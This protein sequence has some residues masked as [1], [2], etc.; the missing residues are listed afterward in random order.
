MW[1]NRILP[2]SKLLNRNQNF[3]G[4]K[5][6][7]DQIDTA[8]T[9]EN[10]RLVILSSFQ[11]TG[12]S[13]IA[14]EIG[15]RF[16]ERSLNQFVY[17]M[18][19]DEDNLNE[20]FRQFA[21]DLEVITED[22][23]LQKPIG[24][25]ITK[26][27]LSFRS[28]L[29]DNS[30]EEFLF[31]FDNCNEI[32]KTKEYFGLMIQDS[33]L[34]NV[35]FLVTTIVGTSFEKLE[36]I[37]NY[38]RECSENIII[39]PFKKEES[40]CF[41]KSKLNN[42]I[43]EE[44]ELNALISSLD[45]Q[46]E[47]PVTLV[48]I[49]ALVKVKLKSTNDLRGLIEEFK[50][51]KRQT[52]ALDELF[53]NL[54]E[55]EEKSWEILKQISFLDA[56]LSP[57]S[58]YTDLFKVQEKE[59]YDAID[60][61]TKLSLITTEEDDE[62]MEYGFRIHQ[63]LQN[64]AKKFLEIKYENEYNEILAKQLDIIE[65]ILKNQIE[66][67]QWNKQKY[68]N[69]FKQII[70]N[71]LN[72]KN[73]NDKN[74]PELCKKF[75]QY[76][77]DANL[78]IENSL[79]YFS[80]AIEIGRN[81]FGTDEHPLIVFTLNSIGLVYNKLGRNDEALN[82]FSESLELNRKIFGTGDNSSIADTLNNIALACDKLCNY[83]EALKNYSLSLE[84]NRRIF[85]TD[86]NTS[87]ADTL[88][89]IAILNFKLGKHEEA[90]EN[91]FK[92]LEI[93]R[94]IFGTEEDL[95]I[96]DNLNNIAMVYHD[97]DNH[98]AAL[99]NY[100]KSLEIYKKIFG[101]EE[102]SSVA[103]TLNN[104]GLVYHHLGRHEDALENYSKSLE[105]KQK[106][107]GTGQNLSIAH[108]LNNIG[109][110]NDA[111]DQYDEAIK[112]YS[113]SL[114]INRIILGTDEHSSIAD[115]LNNIAV[116]YNKVERYEEALENLSKSLEIK[117]N[118]FGTYQHLSIARTFSNFADVYYAQSKY[119]K[120]LENY[121]KSLEIKR[122]TLGTDEHKTVANTINNIGSVY[123]HL[124]RHEEALENYSK[125]LAIYRKIFGTNQHS[126]IVETMFNIGYVYSR[127][128][129]KSSQ[130]NCF[131]QYN[132]TNNEVCNGFYLFGNC[133]SYNDELNSELIFYKCEIREDVFLVLCKSCLDKFQSEKHI[134]LNHG[135]PFKEIFL[136]YYW[137]CCGASIFG[138]CKSNFDDNTD[139]YRQFAC[140]ICDDFGLCEACLKEP[141][142]GI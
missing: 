115:N 8:F 103:Q 83:K 36:S 62:G 59:F 132:R 6:Y 84:I 46:D 138:R 30:R 60:V 41:I 92:S 40:V 56:D 16:N 43:I 2:P 116:A 58:I 65:P 73:L 53:E 102:H 27:G 97:K 101:T 119:E 137:R 118:I 38:I 32:E 34:T 86:Q 64:D 136:K 120:A 82:K 10:K 67:N 70:D 126:F 122:K 131:N 18:R 42:T 123:R 94:K 66:T 31:I 11:G 14:N 85:G 81:I 90:L 89:N 29:K 112:N 87:I 3:I 124:G 95:S 21:F 7:L 75:A 37:M 19:S 33:A 12:K 17:W 113:K 26:V 88:N 130:R 106:V 45:I 96:A 91:C 13:S 24:Y 20:K 48:K 28:R 50:L 110:V 68:Y 61:L 52:E 141:L 25:I 107:F 139:E 135:H 134:S 44:N 78:R 5:E 111:L 1:F 121:S 63:T 114:E 39:E 9:K 98:E 72:N 125:S 80:K 49:I 105:I 100:S 35:N 47:R 54:I 117:R 133:L 69:N 129:Y 22:E 104:I 4:R 79:I 99:E 76:S 140:T 108:T 109:G 74:K 128:F 127:I 93:N 55:K 23:K 142:I 57:F 15:H 77:V 51:N 71:N